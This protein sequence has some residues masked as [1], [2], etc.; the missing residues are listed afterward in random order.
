MFFDATFQVFMHSR[1]QV[2]LFS[3]LALLPVRWFLACNIPIRILFLHFSSDSESFL[4]N[5]NRLVAGDRPK[6][7]WGGAI[8]RRPPQLGGRRFAAC[9]GG[10][11]AIRGMGEGGLGKGLWPL[12]SNTFHGLC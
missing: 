11:A 12:L 10:F 4:A 8:L 5:Q 3:L 1:H 6:P 2:L 7:E 9:R